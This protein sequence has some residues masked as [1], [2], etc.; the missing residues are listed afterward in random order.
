MFIIIVFIN[1]TKRYLLILEELAAPWTNGGTNFYE[2]SC[3][4]HVA[5][6]VRW[7]WLKFQTVMVGAVEQVA[8]YGRMKKQERFLLF[9]LETGYKVG[10]GYEFEGE[11]VLEGIKRRGKVAFLR[12]F[13]V[14]LRQ[15][16][17]RALERN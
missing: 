15:N 10:E 6:D 2:V 9:F 5:L 7:W 17:R 14:C 16:L 3:M 11:P 12:S 13:S 1:S 8:T 4:R